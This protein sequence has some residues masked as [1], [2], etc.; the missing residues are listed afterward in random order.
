[1]TVSQGLTLIPPLSYS[2][3]KGP[4]FVSVTFL[5]LVL[6][7]APLIRFGIPHVQP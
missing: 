7:F 1:M 5:F 3:Y 6:T 4:C 2:R